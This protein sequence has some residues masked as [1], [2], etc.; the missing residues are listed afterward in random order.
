MRGLSL[1]SAGSGHSCGYFQWPPQQPCSHKQ[2]QEA[3]ALW[4]WKLLGMVLRHL[5]TLTEAASLPPLL[6]L[7]CAYGIAEASGG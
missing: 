5:I 6:V 1:Q 7:K 2:F 4:S 3:A